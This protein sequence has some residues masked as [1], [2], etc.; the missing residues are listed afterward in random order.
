V[1]GVAKELLCAAI[2]VFLAKALKGVVAAPGKAQPE[3]AL[4]H[5]IERLQVQAL[6]MTRFRN[7]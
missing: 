7:V 6:E 3:A 5:C 4:R 2:L 1:N